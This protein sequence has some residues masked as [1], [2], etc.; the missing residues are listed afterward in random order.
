[1]GCSGADRMI[2]TGDF[3]VSQNPASQHN[4]RSKADN[5][6]TR[7]IMGGL[8]NRNNMLVDDSRK[9]KS[10]ELECLYCP[11]TDDSGG[12]WPQSRATLECAVLVDS[13]SLHP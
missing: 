3:G 1:M 11:T 6:T 12:T 13:A 10:W 5:H 8:L 4:G 7:L 9:S 2:R